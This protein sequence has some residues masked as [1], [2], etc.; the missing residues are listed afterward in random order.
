MS[1]IFIAFDGAFAR[2]SF[3]QYQ[4]DYVFSATISDEPREYGT[5]V[6]RTLNPI[7]AFCIDEFAE[8]FR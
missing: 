3:A 1:Y 4:A 8:V 6:S 2:T 5:R 7:I